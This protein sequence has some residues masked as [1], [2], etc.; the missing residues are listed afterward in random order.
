MC[1]L[2]ELIT[3]LFFYIFELTLSGTWRSMCPICRATGLSSVAPNSCHDLGSNRCLKC[4]MVTLYIQDT[5]ECF[6]VN[7]LLSI[8]WSLKHCPAQDFIMSFYLNFS[9]C[10]LPFPNHSR[11]LRCSLPLSPQSLPRWFL[12]L[13]HH[14]IRVSHFRCCNFIFYTNIPYLHPDLLSRGKRAFE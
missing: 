9:K 10:I 5:P 4:C 12:S 2:R 8:L 3:N 14:K 6:S 1:V 7:S 13:Y 11:G